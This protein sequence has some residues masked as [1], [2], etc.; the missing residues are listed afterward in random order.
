[1][2]AGERLR[3][4]R[5]DFPELSPDHLVWNEPAGVSRHERVVLADAHPARLAVDD[6]TPDH[7]V[8]AVVRL[9]LARE[10]LIDVWPALYGPSVLCATLPPI[11][12]S[13]FA[14][15]RAWTGFLT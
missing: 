8:A 5:L 2:S 7:R 15:S 4:S 13:M 10:R 14:P 9:Q 11:T 3:H 12:T 6:P 1:M